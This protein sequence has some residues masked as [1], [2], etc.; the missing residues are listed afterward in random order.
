MCSADYRLILDWMTG[1]IDTFYTQ[2][3]TTGNY[4]AIADL[5]ILQFTATHV[6]GF[7]VLTSRILATEFNSL[8]V[9]SNHK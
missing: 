9:T 3:R 1:F 8:T 7:S 5:R 6:L 4:S 2:L